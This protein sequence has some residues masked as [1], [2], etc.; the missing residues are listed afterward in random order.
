MNIY[1]FLHVSPIPE[2]IRL[3]LRRYFMD[4]ELYRERFRVMKAGGNVDDIW[5]DGTWRFEYQLLEEDEASFH[6]Q[7]LLRRARVLRI[8]PPPIF[9]GDVLSEDY[10]RSGLDG[11]RYYL[12]LLGEQKVR[13]AIREEEKYRSERW[14]RRIPY[15]TAIS[16]LVGMFTGLVAVLVN[17]A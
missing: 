9:E 16:G 7:Q 6:S 13:S 17:W 15:I 4:R 3:R 1:R 11:R 5:E 12:S 8:P 2:G 10:E 14:A